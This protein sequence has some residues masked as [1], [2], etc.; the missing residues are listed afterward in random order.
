MC[1]LKFVIRLTLT[2]CRHFYSQERMKSLVD[3]KFQD[4]VK[5]AVETSNYTLDPRL[6]LLLHPMQTQ[7][8]EILKEIKNLRDEG[9]SNKTKAIEQLRQ[10]V[11]R[12]EAEVDALTVQNGQLTLA[13]TQAQDTARSISVM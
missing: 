5:S 6:N 8:E 4:A 2:L 11:T 10:E 9:I 3:A 13:L 12:F 1:P 7:Y